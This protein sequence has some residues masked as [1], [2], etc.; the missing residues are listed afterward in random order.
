VYQDQDQEPGVESTYGSDE[1]EECDDGDD[2]DDDDP[3]TPTGT[4]HQYQAQTHAEAKEQEAQAPDEDHRQAIYHSIPVSHRLQGGNVHVFQAGV[5]EDCHEPTLAARDRWRACTIEEWQKDGQ[6][7]AQRF[8]EIMAQVV[9]LMAYVE[10]RL[11]WLEHRP[12]LTL[13]RLS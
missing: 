5:L 1:D 2:D 8:A 9:Q 12:L 6:D 13:G 11:S 3:R 4:H 7:L 10:L